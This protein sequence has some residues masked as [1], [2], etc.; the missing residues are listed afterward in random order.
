M[1][2]AKLEETVKKLEKRV[3]DLESE[4]SELKEFDTLTEDELQRG[5]EANEWVKS[6]D[7]SKLVK[8]K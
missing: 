4:I 8:V 7:L 3:T 6:G 1:S 2:S 5:K